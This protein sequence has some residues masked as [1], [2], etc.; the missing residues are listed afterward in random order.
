MARMRQ[1]PP[2]LILAALLVA[3]LVYGFQ[4]TA[5][6]PALPVVQSDLGASREW[7]SWL[8]SGYFIVAAVAPLFLGKVADRYGKRRIYLLALGI[9]TIGSVGAAFSPSIAV[10]V[11]CR[12]VQGA[13]GA[14]FPLSFSILRDELPPKR[15][16]AG[17]GVLTG[18]FGLGALAGFGIGGLITEFVSWRWVFG[19]GAI[20]LV[21]A[22]ML[23]WM[24]VP[25][26]SIRTPRR[27]DTLGALLFGAAIAA[28][29]VALT[30][31]PSRGWLSPAVIGL[32]AVAAAAACGWLVR[33]LHTSEP[34][35]DLRVLAS[36]PVLFTNAAS[37]M[38]GYSVIG[39]NIL[40]PFLLS[41]SD[42]GA[43]SMAF[44]LTAGP[45]LT[46]IVLLPRALGQSVGGP[47]TARISRSVGAGNALAIA[48]A[49][50]AAG[51][52]ASG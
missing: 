48:L 49:L 7:T 18:G 44:G 21:L 20:A 47:L 5:I 39:V 31:A 4:Q 27:L 29:I 32:F 41:G 33:E 45:L 28:L 13:G 35:M 52:A 43:P 2:W 25:A 37:I 16:G 1:R 38:S 26:N 15:I 34:L 30:E 19:A 14:V 9:F 3:D 11:V 8:L 51:A 24:V 36:R 17:I 22:I 23:V 10:L 50:V 42:S 12:L 46:G 40:V 6:T